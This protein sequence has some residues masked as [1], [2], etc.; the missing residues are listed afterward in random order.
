MDYVHPT[1]Q[2][3]GHHEHLVP[4]TSVPYNDHQHLIHGYSL[5]PH[6]SN[7][8]NIPNGQKTNETKPR[9][10]K[11]EVDVLEREFNKNPKPTTQTKRHFAETMQV[12]LSRINV[13]LKLK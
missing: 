12:D 7:M 13:R 3:F 11:D 1:F 4:M 6:Q 2:H 10:G 5:S 8:M 9:L